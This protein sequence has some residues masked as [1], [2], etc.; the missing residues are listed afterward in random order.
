MIR[1]DDMKNNYIMVNF[2]VKLIV[3]IILFLVINITLT[4]LFGISIYILMIITIILF[5]IQL[6]SHI[7]NMKYLKT[8]KY[9]LDDN[10]V[11]IMRGVIIKRHE[12]FPIKR[13]QHISYVQHIIQRKFDIAEVIIV[14]GG[15]IGI[16]KIVELQEAKELVEAINSSLNEKLDEE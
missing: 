15:E 6:A 5:I 2:I 7:V 14:T 3:T 12:R 4:M 8:F 10:N 1:G 16:L 9:S 13:V 11:S